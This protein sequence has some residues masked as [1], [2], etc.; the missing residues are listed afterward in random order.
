MKSLSAHYSLD[1]E[2]TSCLCLTVFH[3]WQDTFERMSSVTLTHGS[4]TRSLV[5]NQSLII[6]YCCKTHLVIIKWIKWTGCQGRNMVNNILYFWTCDVLPGLQNSLSFCLELVLMLL[7]SITH[8]G[9]SS[10]K[11]LKRY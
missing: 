1:L 10:V 8:V 3:Q 9:M 11:S 7:T 5:Y 6:K 2:L 4:Q